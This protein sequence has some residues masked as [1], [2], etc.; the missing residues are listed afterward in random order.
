MIHLT[1]RI[2]A[3]PYPAADLLELVPQSVFFLSRFSALMFTQLQFIAHLIRG[4]LYVSH[5]AHAYIWSICA[6]IYEYFQIQ[7]SI[8]SLTF[9]ME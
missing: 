2:L 8:M 3:I 4:C 1:L 7:I 6:G 9:S 5:L